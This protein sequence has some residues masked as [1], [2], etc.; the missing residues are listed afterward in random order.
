MYQ[1][2]INSIGYLQTSSQ[3]YGESVELFADTDLGETPMSLVTIALASC[4]NMCV[5]SFFYHRFSQKDVQV[6]TNAQ[7]SER[8]VFL[9]IEILGQDTLEVASKEQLISFIESHCKVKKLLATDIHFDYEFSGS[10]E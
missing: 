4:V 3:A 7:L 1:T 6:R 9:Q 2:K 5:Q 10:K 8:S